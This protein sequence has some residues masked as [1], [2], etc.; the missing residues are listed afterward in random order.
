MVFRPVAALVCL[1]IVVF[2]SAA[3]ASAQTDATARAVG[4]RR[5][6]KVVRIT[7]RAKELRLTLDSD[8]N[9]IGDKADGVLLTASSPL[10]ISYPR[11]NPLAVQASASTSEVDDPTQGAIAKLIEAIAG[12]PAIVRPESLAV[13][14]PT[15]RAVQHMKSGMCP[16]YL[17]VETH[18]RTIQEGLYNGLVSAD[19]LKTSFDGWRNSIAVAIATQ[20]GPDAVRGAMKGIDDYLALLKPPLDR[21]AKAIV[22]IEKLA[23][24][25]P[26]MTEARKTYD[27][28]HA[29]VVKRDK[30][31]P[32]AKVLEGREPELAVL[33][34]LAAAADEC[35][36]DSVT[37]ASLI[38]LTNPE[39]RLAQIRRL[40]KSVRELRTTLNDVYANDANWLNGT[41]YVLALDVTTVPQR[42]R[43]VTVKAISIG[44]DASDGALSVTRQDAASASF[45]VQPHSTF[46]P[47]IGVGATFGF[48]KRPKYGTGKDAA[49][50]TV[51]TIAGDERV[52]VDPTVMLNLVP[53]G[54]YGAVPMMQLGASV[55]KTSPAMFLGGGWRLPGTGTNGG[56]GVGVGL[57]LAWV[58][59]L[60]KLHEGS[61]VTGTSDIEA[62]LAFD[63]QPQPRFYLNLQYKF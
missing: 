21:A 18:L 33:R 58:K 7:L 43:R 15:P 34:Q 27:T 24:Q 45:D 57:M 53:R 50:Q 4:A 12:V 22:D 1:V 26:L 46:V 6:Q 31:R 30:E 52:S 49:G 14:S 39:G 19:G 42:L 17:E 37:L 28:L 2:G 3:Q 32:E 16:A 47:E 61:V 25:H 63:P 54:M 29:D 5:V 11:L 38:R 13:I 59:D 62:D 56:V 48:V 41:D 44:I 60:Q 9:T 51:V 23:S 40:E 20:P 8:P 55:S 36:S 10:I 35:A